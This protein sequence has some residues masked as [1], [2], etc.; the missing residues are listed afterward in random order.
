MPRE[1]AP[2]LY[3]IRV[4]Y[5]GTPI[6]LRIVKALSRR[7]A[8]AHVAADMLT[9]GPA[10]FADGVQAERQGVKPEDATG[11]KDEPEGDDAGEGE[12]TDD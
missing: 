8:I 5:E 3:A 9:A 6:G 7:Q 2:V 4:Q 12:G 11:S 1:S 10:T